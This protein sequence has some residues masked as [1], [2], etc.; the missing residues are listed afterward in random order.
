MSDPSA[1]LCPEQTLQIPMPSVP[2]G[3][4]GRWREPSVPEIVPVGKTGSKGARQPSR[5]V[6]GM[7]PCEPMSGRVLP[8]QPRRNTERT[9][10]LEV[11]WQAANPPARSSRDFTRRSGALRRIYGACGST[12]V[13]ART[14]GFGQV[15]VAHGPEPVGGLGRPSSSRTPDW[16]P[17]G[18]VGVHR[19]LRGG[20]RILHS[21]RAIGRIRKCC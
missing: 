1:R 20:S 8:G 7:N 11:R 15:T 3:P 19:S 18:G 6:A 14:D 12:V 2:R 4:C 13:D 5:A 16:R 21:V 9:P 17:S 10:T